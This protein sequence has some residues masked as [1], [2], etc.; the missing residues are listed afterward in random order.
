MIAGLALLLSSLLIYAELIQP[1]YS[2][3]QQTKSQRNS[4]QAFLD[5]EKKVVGQ[6]QNL[7]NSYKEQGGAQQAV[8]AALPAEKDVAGALAQIYGLVQF[9]GMATQGFGVSVGEAR[10][11]KTPTGAGSASSEAAD[12]SAALQKPVGNISFDMQL[13]GTYGD[14]K[15]FLLALETNMRL[16]DVEN[17]RL[18]ALAVSSALGKSASAAPRDLFNYGITVTTYYQG[19]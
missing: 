7:L 5:G 4:L 11:K 15:K 18:G 6:V 12:F 17:V 14:F 2:D 9:N 13:N 3:A 1:A 19:Q 8:S 16:F 10:R